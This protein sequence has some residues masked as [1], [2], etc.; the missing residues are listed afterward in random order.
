MKS[1]PFHPSRA[2]A[3]GLSVAVARRDFSLRV[4]TSRNGEFRVAGCMLGPCAGLDTPAA[5]RF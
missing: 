1:A 2:R 3:E 5:V 4:L